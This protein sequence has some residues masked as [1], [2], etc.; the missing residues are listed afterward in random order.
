MKFA[1]FNYQEKALGHILDKQQACLFMGCGLGKTATS[2]QAICDLYD[3]VATKGILVVA[4]LRVCNLTWGSEVAKWDNFS[5]MRV[6]NLRTDAGWDA[7]EQSS[8]HIYVCNYEMLPKLQKLYLKGRRKKKYAFDTVIWDELTRAK[9]YK[10]SRIKAVREYF[11]RMGMRMWGLTGEPTPNSLLEIFGQI[12][13]IDGGERLGKSEKA[14]KERYFETTDFHGRKWKPK[15]YAKEAIYRKISDICLTL[16]TSDYLKDVP[17]VH[18]EDVEVSLGAKVMSLYEEMKEELLIEIGPDEVITAANA[19][20]L[21]NKLTQITSGSCKNEEGV[22][23]DIH[24]KKIKALAGVYSKHSGPLF[25]ICHFRREQVRIRENFPEAI[26]FEDAKTLE[27]QKKLETE[28]NKGNIP[29]LVANPQSVGHGLNLQK[30]GNGICW[31]TCCW[32][33][34]FYNQ[35]NFRLYRTGQE[36]VVIIYRLVAIGTI[37]EHI[38]ETLRHKSEQ[39]EE[40]LNALEQM[41]LSSS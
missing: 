32:S 28:W 13:L 21:C 39:Q 29:M 6:A 18:I 26:F 41:R 3:D 31:F 30:G 14:F 36:S 24:D 33:G 15:L 7:L 34:E 38:V 37:D 22:S 16:K 40:F 2:L 1:P 11:W 12:L 9:N 23:V 10:S 35:T 19:A 25:V 4:P 5:W 8:A 17:D 20:V 27:E